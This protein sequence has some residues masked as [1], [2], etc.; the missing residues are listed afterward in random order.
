MQVPFEAAQ[1]AFEGF[2]MP[3][4]QASG[5]VELL[6]MAEEGDDTQV[7]PDL[8]TFRKL[9]GKNPTSV[10]GWANLNE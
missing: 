3:E 2:G 4:W 1:K 10:R 9:T 6:R 8:S 7:T 5:V